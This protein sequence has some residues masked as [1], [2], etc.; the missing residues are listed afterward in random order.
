MPHCAIR[1]RFCSFKASYFRNSPSC[2][3]AHPVTHE[4]VMLSSHLPCTALSGLI[5]ARCAVPRAHALGFAA[6]PL[7]GYAAVILE[8]FT[9]MQGIALKGRNSTAQG[10]SPGFA[11]RRPQA[12]KGRRRKI[13]SICAPRAYFRSRGCREKTFKNEK[14][15]ARSALRLLAAAMPRRAFGPQEFMNLMR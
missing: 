12:L 1:G 2:A 15:S 11:D 5:P 8:V 10:V 4:N 6:P 14:S 3:G 9:A 7:R 13:E